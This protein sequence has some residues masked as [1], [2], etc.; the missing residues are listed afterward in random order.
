MKKI[1]KNKENI[2]LIIL[3]LLAAFLRLY[4]IG[5]YM[6]FLGDEGRDALVVYD[7]LHG[8]LTLL[9]PTSSVGGFFLGPIYYYFMAPF[10]WLFQYDPVGP[11]V[12]VALFGVATVWLVYKVG[13]E[14]FNRYVGLLA[15]LFYTISP[16]VIAYSRS[17]WNPNL[18]P[19]FALLT[20]YLL[21]KSVKNNSRILLV[22]C[23]ILFGILMQ[24]HYIAVFVGVIIAAYLLV[25]RIFLLQGDSVKETVSKLLKDYVLFGVG[26]II[27]WSPFL[28]FEIRHGFPN[29]QSILK[30]VFHSGETGGGNQLF[31]NI[32]N[33]FFRLFARLLT[34]YPSPE[35]ISVYDSHVSINLI[36]SSIKIP[37]L[38]LFIFTL[39]I[40]LASTGLFLYQSFKTIKNKEPKVLRI[41]LLTV[42]FILGIFIFGFYKKNIYDYYLGFM[43]PLPFFFLGN[44]LV[45][46]YQGSKKFPSLITKS[47]VY[48]FIILF[49]I[50]N[51]SGL[52]FRFAP[53]RQKAQVEDISKF[54]LSKTN[55]KPFNFAL[56]TL[57]NSD[58][59]YRYFF[60]INGKDPVVIQNAQLDPKRKSVTDQL[61]IICED[62]N[63]KPL[64]AS[65]WEVAGFGRAEIADKWNVSVVKVYKLIHYNKNN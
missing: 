25:T 35:Q 37:V 60:K 16:L 64:G 28:A 15:A 50:L 8:N 44:F 56:L 57:G 65:L 24:L 34:N 52:P 18:M 42:W 63:C 27:G 46:I 29:I 53:N 47:I 59:A 40:A 23:G 43:Y 49:V 22:M 12:M 39:I 62:A 5:D 58:H 1:F 30:F 21:Y 51:L 19:F 61:L 20:M 48:T 17:S 54:I 33:V 2:F 55:K 31:M 6:T 32:W 10:L 36:D 11:A 4:K 45:K 13:S 26:F 38:Y 9:G 7:I 3:L 41:T 14:F